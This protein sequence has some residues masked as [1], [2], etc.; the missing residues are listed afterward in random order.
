MT[1]LLCAYNPANTIDANLVRPW[2]KSWKH[3]FH[4][5]FGLQRW[6]FG[7]QYKQTAASDIGATADFAMLLSLSPSEQ[8]WYC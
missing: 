1:T 3:N 8:C 6:V 2:I 4:L 7:T 5:H